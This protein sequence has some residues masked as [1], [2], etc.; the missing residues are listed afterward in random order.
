MRMLRWSL[1]WWQENL[2][3]LYWNQSFFEFINSQHTGLEE[4]KPDLSQGTTR[5]RRNL[6]RFHKTGLT[7]FPW[8]WPPS[9]A[10]GGRRGAILFPSTLAA[11]HLNSRPR[12]FAP[13]ARVHRHA[14]TDYRSVWAAKIA[15]VIDRRRLTFV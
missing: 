4:V 15:A 1:Y 7:P 6:R 14:L 12:R 10:V 5:C 2:I 11:L 13:E 8:R 3:V 9:G